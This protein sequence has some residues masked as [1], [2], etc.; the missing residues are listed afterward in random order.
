MDLNYTYSS[1]K[2]THNT[3]ESL[4]C[5]YSNEV[6]LLVLD[7]FVLCIYAIKLVTKLIWQ[8][9]LCLSNSKKKKI[10]NQNTFGTKIPFCEPYW[11]QGFHSPYYRESHISLR[12]KVRLFVENELPATNIFVRALGSEENDEGFTDV[13]IIEVN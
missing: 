5:T 2:L 6:I 9:F 1:V 13:I 12:N 7:V 4:E 11:Y 3:D 8:E 10:M